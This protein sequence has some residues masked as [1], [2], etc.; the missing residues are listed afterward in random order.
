MSDALVE[1]WAIADRL[2]RY[3]LDEIDEASLALKAGGKGRSVGATFAHLHN[4]RLLWLKSSDPALL[5]GLRKI[6][7][8]DA[9]SK[10]MLAESLTR[11][12]DAIAAMLKKSIAG[13]GRVKGFKPHVTAFVGYLVAHEAHHRG[14]IVLTLKLEGT[15]VGKKTAFGLWEW[16]VR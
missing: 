8:D 14:Q 4:V 6:E 16:G 12:G 13:D 7:A 10:D 2:N 5:A 3:L 15:P 1:T 9:V 11:S